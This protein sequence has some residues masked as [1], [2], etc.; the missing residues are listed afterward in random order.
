MADPVDP[1]G[2]RVNPIFGYSSNQQMMNAGEK[3]ELDVDDFAFFRPRQ[4]EAV[5]MYFGDIAVFQ[6]GE[7]TARWPVFPA[8]A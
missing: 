8:S 5:F 6:A 1:P 4:S 3:L 2:L 7:I